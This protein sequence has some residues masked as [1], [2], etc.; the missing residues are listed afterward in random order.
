ML[1]SASAWEPVAPHRELVGPQSV[2]S[3]AL[4][5]E[6]F[7]EQEGPVLE[8]VKTSIVLRRCVAGFDLLQKR[9]SKREHIRLERSAQIPLTI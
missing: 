3:L 4:D 1:V 2:L 9:N 5:W 8:L 6:R 7:A